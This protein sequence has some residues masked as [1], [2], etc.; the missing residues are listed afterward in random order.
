[1]YYERRI[2]E[3]KLARAWYLVKKHFFTNCSEYLLQNRG[4]RITVR[5]IIA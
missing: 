1:M 5:A 2:I 3:H 4:V